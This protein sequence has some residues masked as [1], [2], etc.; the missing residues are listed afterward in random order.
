GRDRG[1]LGRRPG[2]PPRLPP[3]HGR[4]APRPGD[5][6]RRAAL[7]AAHRARLEPRRGRRP[8]RARPAHRAPARR[9]ALPAGRAR[10]RGPA[11][12]PLGAAR[13]AA[14][15]A[16]PERR[17]A[18]RALRGRARRARL[19]RRPRPDRVPARRRPRRRPRDD[20]R[21]TGARPLPRLGAMKS[22]EIRETFLSYFEQQG[23]LRRPSAS[24]IPSREDTS[25]LLTIAGMQPF[26]PYF[27]G[28]EKP[29]HTRLTSCQ[30]CFRTPDIEEVGNT[31]RHLTFFEMLGNFSFGDYFKEEAIRFGWELSTQGFGF[32]PER[33][34]VTVFAGDD[35]LGLGP[36][37]EAIEVW[38]AQGVPEARIIRLPRSENFWQ[39]GP[40]GPCGPCS[41]MYVDR[42][43]EFGGDD[44]RPGDD[45]ERYLEYWNHVFMTYEL[46]EDGS[47]SDLPKRNI[48]TGLG[49]ERMAAIQQGVDSVFG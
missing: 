1:Q 22:A 24:L 7:R 44:E 31:K 17:R 16:G 28:R 13:G 38:K 15:R 40:T 34:W 35:E 25:T 29:P 27:A 5:R 26:K 3:L 4:A 45:T 2:A 19:R 32:D 33:I 30:R 43:P 47:L 37:T 48:D 46:H 6:R 9:R 39:A 21:L 12:L 10:S 49:L 23:H 18:L 41:E 8:R 42:G 36:D 20:R 14:R 11:A